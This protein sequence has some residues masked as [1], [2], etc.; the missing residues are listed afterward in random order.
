[1]GLIAKVTNRKYI[2]NRQKSVLPIHRTPVN[3]KKILHS[4]QYSL[5]GYKCLGD[6][7]KLLISNDSSDFLFFMTGFQE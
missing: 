2:A 1:M 7:F 4:F 5:E 6:C 3:G